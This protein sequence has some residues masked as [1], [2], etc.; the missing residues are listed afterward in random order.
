MKKVS[1]LI[2]G[3]F[4]MVALN[5]FA[6]PPSKAE[7]LE[8]KGTTW[9]GNLATQSGG[10]WSCEMTLKDD[11]II[12]VKWSDGVKNYE[13]KMGHAG[14]NP[15]AAIVFGGKDKGD[16]SVVRFMWNSLDEVVAEWWPS[17]E[18]Q[19]GQTQHKPAHVKGV[20]TRK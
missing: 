7:I 1:M 9:A 10:A 18:A 19:A 14:G 3:F 20:I 17:A 12:D 6:A 8:L 16:G 11:G 4:T 5:A 13:G 15:S 2:V